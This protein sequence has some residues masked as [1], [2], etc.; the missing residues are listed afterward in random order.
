MIRLSHRLQDGELDLA[1]QLVMA[2]R[3]FGHTAEDVE[4]FGALAMHIQR[5]S[6]FARQMVRLGH[7]HTGASQQIRR[8]G[9]V[10]ALPRSNPGASE[11][12]ASRGGKSWR[13]VA[14]ETELRRVP[15]RLLE[16][17]ADDLVGAVAPRESS[18]RKLVQVSAFRLRDAAICDIADEHVVKHEDV[19]SRVDQRAL[20]QRREV[21][22]GAVEFRARREVGELGLREP[23]AEH[24]RTA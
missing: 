2:V 23:P 10:G 4:R 5:K 22:F 9:H 17:V 8:R 14:A 18:C 15:V 21:A 3:S 11:V 16:V 24:R 1:A 13:A 20:R 7:K 6:E 19:L 12:L